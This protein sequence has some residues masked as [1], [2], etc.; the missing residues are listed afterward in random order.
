[1]GPVRALRHALCRAARADPG[2]RLRALCDKVCRGDVLWRARVMVRVD[3][4]APGIGEVALA[5]VEEHGVARLPGEVAGGPR[6]RRRRPLPARRVLIPEPGSAELRP[7]PIPAVRDRIVR[8]AVKIVLVPVFE[9]GFL[10]CG[11]GFRPGRSAHDALRVLVDECG[12]GRRRGAE[13]D[14]ASCFPA[15]GHEGLVEAAG[16]RICDQP[17]L[18]LPRAMPR[19][20][21]MEDGQARRP[22]TGT[23]RGGVISPVMCDVCLHRL[24]RA[25][26][27]GDGVLA[28]YAGDLVVMC[29]SRRQAEAA[30]E[31][32]TVLLA[33]PRAGA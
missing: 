10:P 30:L 1:M 18:R 7:L 11:Y 23:P 2:R 31:R 22:V 15:I 27:G 28:R 8:A 29:W 9:A 32:L 20:G 16:E 3:D 13:A 17:V 4:G 26:D 25:W 21:V 19:A 14:I 12:R 24:D 5:A 33:G 6:D